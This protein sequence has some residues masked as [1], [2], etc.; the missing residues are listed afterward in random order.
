MRRTPHVAL[1]ALKS[2]SHGP[3]QEESAHRGLKPPRFQK[4]CYVGPESC[5]MWTVTGLRD[6]QTLGVIHTE[7]H[8]E[9]PQLNGSL[10]VDVHPLTSTLPPP[11]QSDSHQPRRAEQAWISDLITD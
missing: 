1:E 11:K 5:D 10:Q 3:S 7:S 8:T 6:G 2:S 9:K 4:V